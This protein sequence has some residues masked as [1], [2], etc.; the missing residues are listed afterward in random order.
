MTRPDRWTLLR[1]INYA[2]EDLPT[3]ASIADILLHGLRPQRA[4]DPIEGVLYAVEDDLFTLAYFMFRQSD[5]I[6]GETSS[7]IAA[8]LLHNIGRRIHVAILLLDRADVSPV[9][10]SPDRWTSLGLN[11]PS[12]DAMPESLTV[13]DALMHGIGAAG[14]TDPLEAILVSVEDDLAALARYMSEEEAFGA[15]TITTLGRRVQ[16]ARILLRLADE[17]QPITGP[18]SGHRHNGLS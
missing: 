1:L 11:K 13:A 6:D 7:T 5:A 3:D 4:A 17:Q 9:E 15:R 2:T 8:N 18:S 16:A 12:N 10:D 14:T